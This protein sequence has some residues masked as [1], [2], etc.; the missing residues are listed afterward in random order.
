LQNVSG[1]ADPL[2]PKET[3]P[4]IAC[5][6]PATPDDEGLLL[7]LFAEYRTA[8]LARFGIPWA[9]AEKLAELQYCGQQQTYLQRYPGAENL[10]LFSESGKAAGRL[11]LDR[12][13]DCWRIVDIG[14]LTEHRRQGIATRAIRACQSSCRALPARL[15]LQVN[16]ANPAR[17][18]YERLGFRV[19]TATDVSLEMVWTADPES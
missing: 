13:P 15:E 18:L 19:V 16:P 8:E 5:S 14:I 6:R 10:I 17:I 1:H 12:Q 4:A 2:T 7:R 11:L 3:W 9:A